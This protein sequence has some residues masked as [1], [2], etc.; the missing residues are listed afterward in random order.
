[1]N[2]TQFLNSNGFIS[3][4]NQPEPPTFAKLPANCFAGPPLQPINNS[5]KK[6][7]MSPY[8]AKVV[9]FIP[10]DKKTDGKNLVLLK[11]LSKHTK[12]QLKEKM[13]NLFS[14]SISAFRESYNTQHV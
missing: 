13:N 11:S 7:D 5:A 4:K 12:T 10:V 9:S 1:M 3:K 6:K 2:T 8:K 14:P